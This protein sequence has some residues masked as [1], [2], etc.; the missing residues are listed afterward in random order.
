MLQV[1]AS[2]MDK[3]LCERGHLLSSGCGGRMLDDECWLWQTLCETP[4]AAS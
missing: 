3:H 2:H 4:L 1:N